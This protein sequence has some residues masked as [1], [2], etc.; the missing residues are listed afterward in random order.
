MD[1]ES[2]SPESL[3]DLHRIAS[4]ACRPRPWPKTFRDAFCDSY[5]CAPERFEQALFWRA[6]HRVAVPVAALVYWLKPDF[7]KEDLEAIRELG[8]A[9]D[10]DAFNHDVN[11]FYAR[12]LRH[13]G[14]LRRTLD[15]RISGKRLIRIRNGVIRS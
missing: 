11:L 2:N 3:S 6:L 5:R 9:R 7:F 13:G 14:F 12:N 8:G 15:L 4:A 1:R 10:A